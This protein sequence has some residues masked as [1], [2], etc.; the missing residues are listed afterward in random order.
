MHIALEIGIAILVADMIYL[1]IGVL[2]W[3][4]NWVGCLPIQRLW[5]L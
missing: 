4:D 1:T 2:Y 5:E 3:K